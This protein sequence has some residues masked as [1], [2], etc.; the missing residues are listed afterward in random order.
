M[1]NID[2]FNI[3]PTQLCKDLRGRF[4]MLYGQAKSGKTSMS[5]MWPKPLLVAFEIGY[6]ALTNVRAQDIASWADFK[7]VCRQLRDPK[8]HEIYETIVIDTVSINSC[9]FSK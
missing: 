4:I 5:V 3:Q 8:A 2:I 9:G 6:N 1:A 7:K